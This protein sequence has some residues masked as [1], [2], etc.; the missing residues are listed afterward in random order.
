[1]E[2]K[3]CKLNEKGHCT[4][5]LKPCVEIDDCATKLLMSKGLS[6]EEISVLSLFAENKNK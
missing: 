5:Y 4:A 1:M 2:I 3:Q 6:L